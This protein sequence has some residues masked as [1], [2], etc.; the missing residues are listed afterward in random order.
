MKHLF[1]L[2]PVAGK[3]KTMKLIPEIKELMEK[4]S[5]EFKIEITKAPGHATGAEYSTNTQFKNLRRWR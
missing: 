3:G 1:I 4:H 5:F 2:N